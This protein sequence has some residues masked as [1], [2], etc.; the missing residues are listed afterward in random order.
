MGK[1]NLATVLWFLAGWSEEEPLEAR[2]LTAAIE[3]AQGRAS[4]YVSSDIGA[5]P[6]VTW[7]REQR[8]RKIG[9]TAASSA[10]WGSGSGRRR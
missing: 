6:P 7:Q 5:T 4:L 10:W 8:S 1:R 2:L 9:N 3:R